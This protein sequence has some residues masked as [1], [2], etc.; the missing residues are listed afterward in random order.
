MYFRS[1]LQ[2]LSPVVLHHQYTAGLVKRTGSYATPLDGSPYDPEALNKNTVWDQARIDTWQEKIGKLAAI[3]LLQKISQ[4]IVK[5]GITV[6]MDGLS[7]SSNPSYLTTLAK[8]YQD[9]VFQWARDYRQ[10]SKGAEW[11][12]VK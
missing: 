7:Q 10:S 3:P 12:F 9:E 11:S 1:G 5:L 2:D 6:S 4:E 8:D